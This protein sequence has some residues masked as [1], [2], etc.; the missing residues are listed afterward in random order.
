M[1]V[2][3]ERGAFAFTNKEEVLKFAV[4]SDRAD[5]LA[6]LYEEGY[7]LTTRNNAPLTAAFVAGKINA[8]H[9]LLSEGFFCERSLLDRSQPLLGGVFTYEDL[10]QEVISNT[11]TAKQCKRYFDARGISYPSS[12]KSDAFQK[13]PGEKLPPLTRCLLETA[14]IAGKLAEHNWEDGARIQ[15]TLFTRLASGDIARVET[16]NGLSYRKYQQ[17]FGPRREQI[18]HFSDAIREVIETY[19]YPKLLCKYP[20]DVARFGAPGNRVD[21]FTKKIAEL[22]AVQLIATGKS[23]LDLLALN[24]K[25]HHPQAK[26]PVELRPLTSVQSWAPLFEPVE[27]ED[28]YSVI[29]LTSAQALGE[30]GRELRHCVGGYAER[31]LAGT[32]H[33]ASIRRDGVPL[34]TLEL[35]AQPADSVLITDDPDEKLTRPLPMVELS[36]RQFYGQGNTAPPP[37]AKAVWEEVMSHIREGTITLSFDSKEHEIPHCSDLERMIGYPIKDAEYYQAEILRHYREKIALKRREKRIPLVGL[38]EVIE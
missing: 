35:Q 2:I 20:E 30:E 22:D 7:D 1:K 27:F 5:L 26:F 23:S 11:Q 16:T 25:W 17:E 29:C 8:A 37:E 32:S 28:G 6:H 12:L 13:R 38:P 34:A 9:Y 10:A 15:H 33:I 4:L 36:V 21:V 24:T 19:T 14:F 18:K 31:C 3:H